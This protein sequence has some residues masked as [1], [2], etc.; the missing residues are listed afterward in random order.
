MRL[1]RIWL[2]LAIA[3]LLWPHVNAQRPAPAAGP[4]VAGSWSLNTYLSDEPQQIANELRYDTG[5]NG[6]D[7]FGGDSGV[8]EGQNRQGRGMRSGRGRAGRQAPNR[9]IDAEDRKKLDELTDTGRLAPTTLSI[10]QSN[11]AVTLTLPVSGSVTLDTNSK[12]QKCRLE[13]GPVDCTASWEGPLLAIAFTIGHAGTLRFTYGLLPGGTQLIVRVAFIRDNGER[14]PFEIKL[15]YDPS[16]SSSG[17]SG[18][19][20]Q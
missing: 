5:E 3:V 11:D 16:K 12:T 1:D 20:R 2:A 17:A 15:V 10:S 8:S 6:F 13:S 7:L 14:G 18:H 9:S 4:G 19:I